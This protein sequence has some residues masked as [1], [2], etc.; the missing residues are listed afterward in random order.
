[1]IPQRTERILTFL[2]ILLARRAYLEAEVAAG[3]I[4]LDPARGIRSVDDFPIANC[5]DDWTRPCSA[6]RLTRAG[7]AF[8]GEAKIEGELMT[9]LAEDM[10]ENY[11]EIVYGEEKDLTAYLLRRTYGEHLRECGCDKAQRERCMGHVQTDE[12]KKNNDFVNENDLK[13][14]AEILSRRPLLNRIADVPV[15]DVSSATADVVLEDVNEVVLDFLRMRQDAEY[16]IRL[17]SNE[18]HVPPEVTLMP[19]KGKSTDVPYSVEFETHH[20]PTT[21]RERKDPPADVNVV[22]DYQ[23]SYAPKKQKKK[24]K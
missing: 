6:A 23:K 11:S 15:I 10:V 22:Y 1:M 5:E 8:L 21:N 14:L 7:R 2:P 13:D 17:A 24:K 16:C 9:T 18:Y 19:Q 12:S 4:A 3:R 20:R